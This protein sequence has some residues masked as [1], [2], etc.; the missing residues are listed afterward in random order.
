M[1]ER[2]SLK[3]KAD[4][5]DMVSS[6]KGPKTGAGGSKMSFA[7]RMMAKMGH[8]EGQGLGKA[9]EGILNPIEVKLRPQGAGVGAVKEKTEQAKAEAKRAAERRG[10]Q[11]EDSSEEERK[12][13]R[14][15]KEI[16][17]SGAASGTSTPGFTKAKKKYRT[18]AEIEA[19]A[20]GLEVPNVLKSLIDATGK[21]TKL[22]TSTAGLMT[23]TPG[24]P[25]AETEAE[26]VA[27]RARRDLE[28]LVDTWND[29]TERKK[30]VEAEQQQVQRELEEQQEEAHRLQAVTAAIESLAKLDLSAPSTTDQAT[31]KWEQVV[32]QLETMQYAYRDELAHYDL[33]SAA[34]AAIH[35]LFKQ[36]MLDWSALDHP[37]RLVPYL[38][39][40]RSILGI[41][42][43]RTSESNSDPFLDSHHRKSTTPYESLIHTLWLPRLRTT[44]TNS[45]DPHSPSSL[46]TLVE[47][48]RDLLPSFIFHSLLNV[49]VVSKLS[50]AVASWNPRTTSKRKHQAPLPHIWLFPWLPYLSAQH[51]SPRAPNGLLADVRRKLRTLLDSWP[52]SSGVLPGL[53]AWR[54]VLRS[55]L[56]H[57]LVRHLLPRLSVHLAD[58]LTIYPPQQ[59]L[60]PLEDV[61]AWHEYFKPHIFAQLFVSEF[62]PKWLGTL[63]AW[64]TGD[65]ANYEEVGQWFTWWKT[66]IP[67]EI[68]AVPL[69]G[70]QW[71]RGL[72]MLNA[73]LDLADKGESIDLPEP[74]HKPV[75]LPADTPAS[76][77]TPRAEKKQK[78]PP[79]P[80]EPES[81]FKDLVEEWCAEQDLTL[82]PLREAHDTTGLPLF[83]ISASADGKSGGVRVFLKGTVMWAQDRKDRTRWEPV[84]LG[85][86]LV[87]R[88][89][90]K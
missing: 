32:S 75:P 60:S 1:D 83:R 61:L 29:V 3:R 12:A 89:E 71:D 19:S 18:A 78:P 52:L 22:L 84:T 47:A 15:R 90:G 64:L 81:S 2:P 54:E 67:E 17:R 34:V 53:D 43:S 50:S 28:G 36:E 21:E 35:P 40:L 37:N 87:E 10:E 20:Q 72:H 68:T 80:V 56:E 4:D 79:A 39:R 55:E 70:E 16:A 23:P 5:S 58:N 51:T 77:P 33:A 48:W 46:L 85:E 42:A 82:R 30:F 69:V 9:G 24:T 74:V 27:S 88:A 86:E 59:D 7:Q 13:R 49:Q 14:R 76:Q 25:S 11:Y 62:F 63:H 8:K 65:S 26:K 38:H 45:W 31:E 44:I 57:S 73:A 6:R 41:E 66:Q